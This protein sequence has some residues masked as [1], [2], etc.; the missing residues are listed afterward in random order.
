MKIY[1][2]THIRSVLFATPYLLTGL[3]KVISKETITA[4]FL[5]EPWTSLGLKGG[6]YNTP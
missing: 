4:P 3:A 6:T 1:K 5:P 2:V